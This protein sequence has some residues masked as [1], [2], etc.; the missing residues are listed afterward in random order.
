[1]QIFLKKSAKIRA[2]I[3]NAFQKKRLE[4][5]RTKQSLF[6]E[7]QMNAGYKKQMKQMDTAIQAINNFVDAIYFRKKSGS[8]INNKTRLFTN[9]ILNLKLRFEKLLKRI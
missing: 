3:D 2:K 1:M 9:A 7:K 4:H 8:Q 5:Q 6:F